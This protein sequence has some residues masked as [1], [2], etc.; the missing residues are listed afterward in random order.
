[1]VTETVAQNKKAK[2]ESINGLKVIFFLA[3]FMMH[4]RGAWSFQVSDILPASAVTGFFVLGG[5]GVGYNYLDKEIDY[6]YGFRKIKHVYPIYVFSLVLAAPVVYYFSVIQNGMRYI[7][8]IKWIPIDLLLLQSWTNTPMNWNGVAWFLS[9][10]VFCY[11]LTPYI[12]KWINK[13]RYKYVGQLIV[14]ASFPYLR[15]LVFWYL[16]KL[17]FTADE[18]TFP[19]SRLFDYCMGLFLAS[20]FMYL[21]DRLHAYTWISSLWVK[22]FA[23]VLESVSLLLWLYGDT[24]IFATSVY[25]QCIIVFIFAFDKGIVS[26]I[27]RTRLFKLFGNYNLEL[28]LIHQ[29]LITYVGFVHQ[30]IV[31]I[32][33]NLKGVILL[34]V[35]IFVAICFR[36][37]YKS[38]LLLGKRKIQ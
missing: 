27:F 35:D 36:K 3:I 30:K 34:S 1:M 29:P 4:A 10:I 12:I 26:D 31:P 13:I 38:I 19:L 8:C 14:L 25:F 6:L 7:D 18:Y 32:P 21:H 28:F 24:I 9:D 15:R 2:I 33:L 16:G 23:S 5:F 11:F 37:A 17:G 22:L 20:I